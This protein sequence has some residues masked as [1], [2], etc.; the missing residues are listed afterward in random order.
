MSFTVPLNDRADYDD[1]GLFVAPT[2]DL[3]NGDAGTVLCF[4]GG[5]P[6]GG[7]P[8]SRGTRKILTA[9]LVSDSN[10]SGRPP[11]YALAAA[12]PPPGRPP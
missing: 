11:G 2:G 9:F 5:V 6:H 10:D 1:G 4:H 3:V 8:I 7:Y 12:P